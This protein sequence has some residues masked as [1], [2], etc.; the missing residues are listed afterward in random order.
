MSKNILSP[1]EIWN[2]AVIGSAG[3]NVACSIKL[4]FRNMLSRVFLIKNKIRASRTV[5]YRY[6]RL[7]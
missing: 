2:R 3:Q 5:T 7:P 1:F 4:Y 6:N